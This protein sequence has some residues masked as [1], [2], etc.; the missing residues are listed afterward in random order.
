[1]K[2]HMFNRKG[3]HPSSIMHPENSPQNPPETRQCTPQDMP[4]CQAITH[5]EGHLLMEATPATLQRQVPAGPVDAVIHA[6]E[7]PHLSLLQACTQETLAEKTF[8][9]M[10]IDLSAVS[11]HPLTTYRI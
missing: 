2:L 11:H 7:R 4:C 9:M 5:K 8:I 6:P 1:M 3:T 10:H